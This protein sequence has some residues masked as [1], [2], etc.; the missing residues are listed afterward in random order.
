MIFKKLSSKEEAEYRLF[1]RNN[2]D[3][4]HPIPGHW[5]PTIQDECIKMNLE[6]SKFVKKSKY[7]VNEKSGLDKYN[8]KHIEA[9]G[10]NGFIQ[11]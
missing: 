2:Y 5:H 3:L 8:R 10:I 7:F 6:N 4:F 1:A 11:K 9:Y